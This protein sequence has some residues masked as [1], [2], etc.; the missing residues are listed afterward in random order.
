MMGQREEAIAGAEAAAA[1]APEV[2]DDFDLRPEEEQA[3]DV[4][5]QPEVWCQVEC[6]R[7]GGKWDEAADKGGFGQR[8]QAGRLEP[9][10]QPKSSSSSAQHLKRDGQTLNNKRPTNNQKV[11]EKL[12][13]RIRSVEVKVLNAP[14]PGKKCLVVRVRERG[15][16][17]RAI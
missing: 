1:A 8:D 14:R 6:M 7:G 12:Q 16:Y 11:L 2:Q 4:R 9:A 13:R 15:G 10:V 17:G 3:L 5:D